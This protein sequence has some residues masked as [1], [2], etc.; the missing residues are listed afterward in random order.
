MSRLAA[1]ASVALS[2]AD[3]DGPDVEVSADDQLRINEFGR[4]NSR[5][6]ELRDIVAG[7]KVGA[8]ARGKRIGRGGGCCRPQPTAAP[9]LAPSLARNSQSRA[10]E[11]GDA[12]EGVLLADESAPGALKMVLGVG[13]FV[14]CD[15]AAANAYVEARR[16]RDESTLAEAAAELKAIAARQADLKA[17]LYAKFGR[18]INLEDAE[19]PAA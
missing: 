2:P 5:K 16:A 8:L 17:L 15:A 3:D 1:P 9:L 6:H 4:L 13:L 7:A 11:L 10:A 19:V 12:E 18:S 14:D